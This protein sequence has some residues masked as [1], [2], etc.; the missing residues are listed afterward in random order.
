MDKQQKRDVKRRKPAAQPTTVAKPV[1]VKRPSL[2]SNAPPKEAFENEEVEIGVDI[3]SSEGEDAKGN[4][5]ITRVI[6]SINA[7]GADQ[8]CAPGMGSDAK[9]T[10]N[11]LGF[12]LGYASSAI[13]GDST[14]REDILIRHTRINIQDLSTD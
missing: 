12:Q 4:P 5:L 9:Y 11:Y 7:E 3:E 8:H 6:F 10:A 13:A 2:K 14:M 1:A